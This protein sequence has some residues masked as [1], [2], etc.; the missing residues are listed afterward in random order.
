MNASSVTTE[1]ETIYYQLNTNHFALP[2]FQSFYKAL[3][4]F[5]SLKNKGLIRNN[6]L[7]LIDFSLSSNVKRLW[8][9]DLS[10]N[11]ILF[12]TLVAHGK[13]TGE[14]FATT[15][16]N[17]TSS[18]KS[19]L[20]LYVTGEIYTGK[21][22]ISL[23]LDGLDKGINDQART[24]AVVVHGAEYVSN[25]FIKLHKRLGRSLGCPAIPVEFTEKIIQ[26]IKNKSCLFIYHS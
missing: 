17:A 18:F 3:E 23:K 12:N 1:A 6:I 22:G 13:N 26:T 8:V 4:G 5:N 11:I 20:G 9:I 24:R 16:S 10:N 2:K 14:E 19:S 15:F 21:H 25:T 7:T